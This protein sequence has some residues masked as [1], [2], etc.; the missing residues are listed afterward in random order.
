MSKV[1]TFVQLTEGERVKIEALLHQG[2]S[3]TR[4]AGALGR[5]V[6]TISRE[7]KRNGPLAYHAF[8]AHHYTQLRHRQKRKHSVFD[9]VMKCFIEQRLKQKKWSPELISIAGRQRQQDF[10]STEW[11]YQW[12]WRMK[13]SQAKEDKAYTHLYEHLR[14]ARRRRKRGNKHT[15]RGNIIARKWI[16]ER[17]Q[18]ANDRQRRGDLEADIILGKD[19]Q[20]GLLV[21]LDRSS[22]KTWLRKLKIKDTDYVLE[23]LS[24]ICE[25]IGDV[26]TV[27]LDNDQSFAEH[28]R[29][30]SSGIQTFFTH[31]YSS[32]EKGSVENR[33]GIIR[34]FFPKKTDF[35]NVTEQQVR[36]VQ[37]LINER[38]LRMFNYKSPNEIHIYPDPIKLKT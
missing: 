1:R 37:N 12:I 33:I 5:P 3:L 38:P 36:L 16:D 25:Q 10:I 14:H 22:R 7:V 26:K 15:M 34:M 17:P 19:R 35:R 24:R 2:F 32:Q 4:I 13:F 8:K 31:P 11:I 28:Y 29:L 18:E 27:T 30:N 6:C 23:K 20:P 21:A 9:H